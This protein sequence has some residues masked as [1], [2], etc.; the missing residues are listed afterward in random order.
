VVIGRGDD[1]LHLQNQVTDERMLNGSVGKHN[2]RRFMGEIG[3][4]GSQL[5]LRDRLPGGEEVSLSDP[6][7]PDLCGLNPG[8]SSKC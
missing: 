8:F 3:R 5:T 6:Y 1:L 4:I 2:G 7:E